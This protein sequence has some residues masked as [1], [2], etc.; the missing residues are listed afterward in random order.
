VFVY[1]ACF[2]IRAIIVQREKFFHLN[3]FNHNILLKVKK[4]DY[5]S[6]TEIAGHSMTL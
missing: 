6:N 3:E 5:G 4:T 2:H 1:Q